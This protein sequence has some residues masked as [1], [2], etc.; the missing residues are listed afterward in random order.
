[1]IDAIHLHHFR[2]LN[3][4]IILILFKNPMKK[5]SIILIILLISIFSIS[6]NSQKLK[7][8][9]TKGVWELGGSVYYTNT[10]YILNGES[11]GDSYGQLQFQPYAGYFVTNNFELGIQPNLNILF[12]SGETYTTTGIYFAPSYNFTIKK[13]I[14]Y[15]EIKALIGY[16]SGSGSDPVSS[17]ETRSGF[18]WGAEG[19]VKINIL[20]N[21]LLFFG[22]QYR[23]ETYNSSSDPARDGYNIITFGAGWKVFF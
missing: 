12:M 16:T 20:G 9:G 18:S 11:K 7:T 22:L 17:S 10:S 15:P 23:Q 19:G 8:F 14:V 4:L 1:M 21:S 2:I 13:S 6:T 3:Y 5:H